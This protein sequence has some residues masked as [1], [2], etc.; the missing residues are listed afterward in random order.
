MYDFINE[1]KKITDFSIFLEKISNIEIKKKIIHLI[2][3]N[4][5]SIRH[6]IKSNNK[7]NN[8]KEILEQVLDLNKEFEIEYKSICVALELKRYELINILL[9]RCNISKKTESEE[10]LWSFL[11][12]SKKD[13]QLED[14]FVKLLENKL[15]LCIKNDKGNL[16]IQYVINEELDKILSIMLEREREREREREELIDD[17]S[18]LICINQ[19]IKTKNIK[20]IKICKDY[21]KY[22]PIDEI[23]DSKDELIMRIMMES[24]ININ[25]IKNGKNIL[26]YILSKKEYKLAKILIETKYKEINDIDPVDNNNEPLIL[27]QY[28]KGKYKIA[29]LLIKCLVERDEIF[30]EENN[31]KTINRLNYYNTLYKLLRYEKEDENDLDE[32]SSSIMEEEYD[33]SII[34]EYSIDDILITLIFILIY[35]KIEN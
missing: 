5:N 14:I 23:I 18:G 1:N 34:I 32:L 19:A 8:D 16:M 26:E 25:N 31:I 17:I 21:G 9:E 22:F 3:I 12:V 2:K 35:V 15:D 24:K 4:N 30:I 11:K 10:I 28:D 7:L 33:N 27:R 29:M 6:I 20:I 13:N